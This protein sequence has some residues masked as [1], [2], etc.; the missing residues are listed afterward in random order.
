VAKFDN[1]PTLTSP[2]M[3]LIFPDRQQLS[4]AVVSSEDI[5]SSIDVLPMVLRGSPSL[6]TSAEGL[7]L[8][9]YEPLPVRMHDVVDA[10]TLNDLKQLDPKSLDTWTSNKL[11]RL[12]RIYRKTTEAVCSVALT[13]N[14]RWPIA[15][16]NG[17]FDTYVVEFG[18]ILSHAPAVLWDA[19]G[20]K[21][22]DVFKCLK[23]MRKAIQASSNGGASVEV[24]A[25]ETAF[26]ALFALAE[27]HPERTSLPVEMTESAISVDGKRHFRWRLPDQGTLRDVPP[28]GH[29]RGRAHRSG[30]DCHDDRQGR[31]AQAD[32]L[33][34]GRHRSQTPAVPFFRQVL[35]KQGPQFV[36]HRR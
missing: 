34:S 21:L 29:R 12:R 9:N 31:R 17:R 24:W 28:T 27:N 33:R 25:G 8:T 14:V 6:P 15:L 3:D 16:S 22:A 26:E 19:E 11:D 7:K 13:G 30:Q 20:A 36:G 32:L 1:L 4:F 10:R 18:D 2:V 23:A 5:L 35:R